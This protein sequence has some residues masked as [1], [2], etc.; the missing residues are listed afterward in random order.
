MSSTKHIDLPLSHKL[1]RL[2]LGSLD[3]TGSTSP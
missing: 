1:L 2:G 3:L